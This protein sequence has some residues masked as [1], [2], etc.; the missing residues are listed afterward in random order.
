MNSRTC[1]IATVFIYLHFILPT[2]LADTVFLKNGNALKVEKAWQEDDQVWFILSD[3]KASIPQSKV[4]RI[5]SDASNPAKPAAPENR[6]NAEMHASQSQPAL[7]MPPNQIIKTAGAASGPQQSSLSTRK[8]LVLRIDGLADMKWGATLTSVRGLEIKQ[9]DSGLQDV[10]EYVRPNDSLKLGGATLKTVVYA[11]WRNQFYTVSIWT[12]GQ[13]NYKALR[14]AAFHQ[15][16]KGTRIDGS[17]E[18]YLWS[19]SHTDVMLK[20][21]SDGQYGLL[22]MRN[23]KLDRKFKLS[24]LNGH[25]SYLKQLKSIK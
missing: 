16:G 23:K 9:A 25:T 21:T 18:K 15:F 19:D 7:K 24:K 1:F 13:E 6:S 14:D 10:I 11:F 12:Q 22:W 4:T 17:I 2:A 8:P 3:M 20:Y 5:E